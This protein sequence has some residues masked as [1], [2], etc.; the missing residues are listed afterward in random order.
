MD[1]AQ[2][3]GG[4]AKLYYKD[5]ALYT[6]LGKA[7]LSRS[8]TEA[9]NQD[10]AQVVWAVSSTRLN[11]DKLMLFIATEAASR[12]PGSYRAHTAS[13]LLLGVARYG[14]GSVE[15]PLGRLVDTLVSNP[16]VWKHA[17]SR[18]V[19]NAAWALACLDVLGRESAK[20]FFGV[21]A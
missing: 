6:A 17:F 9:S 7:V 1:I 14:K 18:D 12:D 5:E 16:G 20:A 19:L 3:F 13:N 21:G 15:W 10:L 2:L 8:P 4:F 11:M